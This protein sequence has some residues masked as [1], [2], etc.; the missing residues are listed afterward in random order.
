MVMSDLLLKFCQY[1]EL[2]HEQ[3]SEHHQIQQNILI[4]LPDIIETN[5]G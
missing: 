1:K 4:D 5:C 2:N 3:K